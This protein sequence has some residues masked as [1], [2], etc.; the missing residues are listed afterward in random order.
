MRW[1]FL[2]L[3]LVSSVL[4]F[5]FVLQDL[6]FSS[7]DKLPFILGNLCHNQVSF[8]VID[9]FTSHFLVQI[10]HSHIKVIHEFDILGL[11]IWIEIFEEIKYLCVGRLT[12]IFNVIQELKLLEHLFLLVHCVYSIFPE[13]ELCCIIDH[14]TLKGCIVLANYLR[15]SPG[16]PAVRFLFRNFRVLSHDAH[17]VYLTELLLIRRNFL[18]LVI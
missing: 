5:D 3:N 8:I 16:C 9:N 14:F 2:L 18:Y 7:I 6:F 1:L 13:G 10:S 11:S 12:H 4:F 17:L 15:R